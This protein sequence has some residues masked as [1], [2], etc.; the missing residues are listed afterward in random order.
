[1]GDMVLE[2]LWIPAFASALQERR[3][4]EAISS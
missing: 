3:I 4:Q 1:M 2:P